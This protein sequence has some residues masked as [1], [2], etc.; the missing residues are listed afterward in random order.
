MSKGYDWTRIDAEYITTEISQ[1][2][3]SEKYGIPIGTIQDRARK[4]GWSEKRKKFRGKTVAKTMQKMEKNEINR[5]S[6][7]IISA[8]KLA[9][10]ID[11]A[12]EDPYMFYKVLVENKDTGRLQ[13]KRTKIINTKKLKEM[14]DAI[15]NMVEIYKNADDSK[16]DNKEIVLH[17]DEVN[18]EWSE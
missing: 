12:L 15:K 7:M 6:S 9:D 17:T 4:E 18:K 10:V 16:D 1:K 2:K 11:K 3:I 13:A 14:S 5:L 8:G